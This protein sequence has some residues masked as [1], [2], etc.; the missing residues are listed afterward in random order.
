[1]DL[2]KNLS[3]V[4][5]VNGAPHQLKTQDEHPGVP[6]HAGMGRDDDDGYKCTACNAD[7]PEWLGRCPT[8][9]AWSSIK[10]LSEIDA[11]VDDGEDEDRGA[12]PIN[13]VQT[14]HVVRILTGISELDRVLGGGAV[15][16]C[17]T[18]VGGDPGVGKS[19]LLLQGLVSISKLGQRALYVT[20]EESAEQVK[21]RAERI[22]GELPDELF[23]LADT[24]TEQII[25]AIE[26]IR[27]SVMVID[28]VQTIHTREGSAGNVNQLRDVTSLMCSL[29]K[30]FRISTFLV[31]HITKDGSLAGPK[32]LEHL[33]DTVLLFEGERGQAFRTLRTQK[34]RYGSSTEVGIFTMTANGMEEVPNPSEFFL[35]ERNPSASGS[36][37]AATNESES[38]RCMLVEVQAMVGNVKIGSGGRT[39]ANGIDSSRLNMIIGILEK[40]LEGSMLG[41]RDI[42][43]S[44]VGGLKINEPALDL[45]IALAIVSS[46]MKQAVPERMVAFGEIGLTGEVRGVPRVQARIAEAES[47]GFHQAV[48]PQSVSG[49]VGG[50]GSKKSSARGIEIVPIRTLSDAIE[51]TLGV[52]LSHP[53]KPGSKNKKRSHA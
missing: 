24:R 19:T 5:K 18:L 49:D 8:C 31:G 43:V 10:R 48:I 23:L 27:P 21:L 17:T 37:I 12:R 41:V 15:P 34:N 51:S 32:V 35:A 28:S 11:D 30:E 38:N 47:M 1:M 29:A 50:R 39:V 53:G 44:I 2:R 45:P 36:I 4:A 14:Q 26:D 16:G 42:F 3:T 33:V 25:A 52:T 9:K 7:F 22:D 20:A 46:L 6:A 13:E 40:H